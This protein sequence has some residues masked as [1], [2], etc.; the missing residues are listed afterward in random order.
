MDDLSAGS[1]SN[2]E[3]LKP[4]P[5]FRFVQAHVA[6]SPRSRHPC[7]VIA[8]EVLTA[9]KQSRAQITEADSQ[10][11]A[12]ILSLTRDHVIR[13]NGGELGIHLAHSSGA[14][15]CNDLVMG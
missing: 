12:A 15:G 14:Q 7:R 9:L 8:R 11:Q 4:Q 2:I 5:G 6:D 13:E 3:H 1:V 10:P